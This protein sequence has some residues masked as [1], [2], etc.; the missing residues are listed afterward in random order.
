MGTKFKVTGLGSNGQSRSVVVEA[1]GEL[2]ALLD[3]L[4]KHGLSQATAETL[5]DEVPTP[6]SGRPIRRSAAA[7]DVAAPARAASTVEPKPLSTRDLDPADAGAATFPAELASLRRSVE[8]LRAEVGQMRERLGSLEPIQQLE[9]LGPMQGL[10]E[11]LPARVS[12]RLGPELRA[13]RL[14]W[15]MMLLLGLLGLMLLQPSVPQ[16]RAWLADRW[17]GLTGAQQP[18]GQP[19]GVEGDRVEGG[20]P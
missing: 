6:S 13:G 8:A 14:G 16:M 17:T 19:E 9:R 10:V 7:E 4:H 18:T 2:E 5:P 20:R 12:E 15:F 1:T 11:S 3:A